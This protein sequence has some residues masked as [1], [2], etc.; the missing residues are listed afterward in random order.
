MRFFVSARIALSPLPIFLPAGFLRCLSVSLTPSL[1]LLP[2]LCSSL[3]AGRLLKS[4]FRLETS[5]ILYHR[6]SVTFTN[7]MFVCSFP[8]SFWFRQIL[9][10]HSA[11]VHVEHFSSKVNP[12]I[13]IFSSRWCFYVSDLLM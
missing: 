9:G 1:L 6:R 7:P 8:S 5:H 13:E 12:V 3:Q 4:L 2:V 11:A 10:S